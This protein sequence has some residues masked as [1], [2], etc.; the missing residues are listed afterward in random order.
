MTQIA[1]IGAGGKLGVRLATNLKGSRKAEALTA[2][3]PD[4]FAYAGD[5]KADLAVWQSARFGLFAGHDPS[6]LAGLGKVTSLEAAHLSNI[7]QPK[8]Y[9]EAVLNFLKS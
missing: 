5:A 9:T 7:E 1:L 6:L 2:R 3:F 8:A 4:G